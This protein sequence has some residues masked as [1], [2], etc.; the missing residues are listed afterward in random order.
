MLE[1]VS[2][3]D[4][5]DWALLQGLAEGKTQAEVAQELGLSQPAISKRLQAI[6]RLGGEILEEL[7]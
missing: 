6:R 1:W 5:I 3:L 7:G 4:A 2:P